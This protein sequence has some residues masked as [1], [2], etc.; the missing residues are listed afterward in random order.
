[1]RKLFSVLLI[2]V[3]CA[4]FPGWAAEK[5]VALVIGNAAYPAAPLETPANDAQDM[6]SALRK[7]GFEVVERTDAD[8]EEMRRAIA[9]FVGKLNAETI[10]LF[11][12]AGHGIQVEGKNYLVPLDARMVSDATEPRATISVNSLLDSLAATGARNI[13]LL[14]ACRGDSFE[15]NVRAG[16]AE[17]YPPKGTLIALSAVPGKTTPDEKGRN[18]LYAAEFLKLLQLPGITAERV[19]KRVRANVAKASGN[20]QV[21][22]VVSNLSGDLYLRPK[23]EPQYA[24]S[25]E[26]YRPNMEDEI[27][28]VAH[29][30]GSEAWLSA[31]LQ[32]F[33]KGAYASVAKIKLAALKKAAKSGQA[34]G[35]DGENDEPLAGRV[36]R[37]CPECPE[38]VVIPAGKFQMGSNDD[39]RE[40]PVHPVTIAQPFALGRTEVTQRQWR[41]IMGNNP[42]AFEECGDDCPVEQVSWEEAKTFVW[43]LSTRTG[44]QYR[45]PSEAEWEYAARAGGS[46][47]YPWGSD[48]RNAC[49]HGNV[50]DRKNFMFNSFDCD[51]DYGNTAP[52]AR[53]RA[54]AFGLYDMVGNVWE[55]VEDCGNVNYDDAPEDGSAWMSGDC[56]S[57]VLRGGSWSGKPEGMRAAVRS[58]IGKAFRI[59]Y[60]GFRVARTLP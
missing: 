35:F 50:R 40:Q 44:E 18:G 23:D 5:R 41:A 47:K 3:L 52:V 9:Q 26:L 11:Y 17:M 33:P 7:L 12:F 27:W 24:I 49:K 36:F 21:P 8:H 38:M 55:W 48:E 42:S 14:D 46:A 34:P 60:I 10:S 2:V 20:Q 30:E 37:D 31:Y 29:A 19:F 43:K 22:W 39:D 4:A 13:V 54:N 6:A 58:R 59:N 57:G 45:L 56:N 25:S 51:D 16:L 32:E 1:M 28:K 15:L 53:F